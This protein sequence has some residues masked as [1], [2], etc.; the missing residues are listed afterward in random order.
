MLGFNSRRLVFRHSLQTARQST[1]FI[2]QQRFASTA[3]NKPA[4]KHGFFHGVGVI[5]K[6]GFYSFVLYTTGAVVALNSPDAEK[7]W[8]KYVPGGKQYMDEVYNVWLN[9]R[10]IGDRAGNQAID[11]GH[12][13]GLDKYMKLPPKQDVGEW[14]VAHPPIADADAEKPTGKPI[15]DSIP[16]TVNASKKIIGE[17]GA[18][19]QKAYSDASEQAKKAYSDASEQA[20]KAV[21]DAQKSFDVKKA[22]LKRTL[23]QKEKQLRQLLAMKGDGKDL[24]TVNLKKIDVSSK[25]AN[26]N[27]LVAS[28]NSLIDSLSTSLPTESTQKIVDQINATVTTLSDKYSGMT[29]DMDK[30]VQ[31]QL[32]DAEAG[33]EKKYAQKLDA[34]SKE[35]A[36]EMTKT[37]DGAKKEMADRYDRKLKVDV[38]EAAKTILMEADNIISLSKARTV[39]ELSHSV[40]KKVEQERNGKLANLEALAS[41]VEQIEA[42]EIEL[43]KSAETLIGVKKISCTLSSINQILDSNVPSETCGQDLV[44]QFTKLRNLT[45]PM[46][47]DVINS[48]LSALPSDRALL[49]TGGVLTQSQLI[50]RWNALTPELRKASLLPPNSGV[51]G[52][53]TSFF[54]S[55]LL[56]KKSGVPE[57]TDDKIVGSDV[58]SVISRVNNYLTKNELNNAVEEVTNMKGWPRQLANDWLAEGRKKLEIQF[59]LG[60]VDTEMTVM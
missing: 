28:I 50:S 39:E 23:A 47:N 16:D 51:M 10:E 36:E 27:S 7:Y 1:R 26:V 41:R 32:L 2:A 14:P 4:K 37:L 45:E 13:I 3:A 53:I 17:K 49:K 40:S 19:V 31:V 25:D 29:S 59:L 15:F 24:P 43:S 22:E 42:Q 12:E 9:R 55:K 30:E 60:V 44:K 57:K 33:L 5:I 11:W 35:Q 18:E 54:F 21:S 48:A 56:M 20:K 58:E 46:H 52:Q 8:V 6:I 38:S 34:K